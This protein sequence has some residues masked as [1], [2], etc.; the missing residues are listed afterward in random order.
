LLEEV[1]MRLT[2]KDAV[3]TA[4]VAA[5]GGL[6]AW[7]VGSPDLAFVGSTRWVTLAVFV[8]GVVACATGASYSATG[9]YTTVMSVGAVATF[10]LLLTGLI[11]GSGTVLAL[12]AGLVAL[13]W[14]VTTVRHALGIYPPPAPAGPDGSHEAISGESVDVS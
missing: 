1:E 6:Y 10:A 13:M 5:A 4:V 8:L 2:G 9:R 11:T 14:L 7:H 3:A 12:L